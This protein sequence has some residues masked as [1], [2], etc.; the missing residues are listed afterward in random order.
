MDDGEARLTAGGGTAVRRQLRALAERRRLS[1]SQR[2]IA[3]FLIDHADEAGFLTS[4]DLAQRV[5]VSQPSATRFA[6][7]LGFAGYPEFRE[8]I[9]S[10]M[11]RP[12]ADLP[13]EEGSGELQRVITHE[14][15]N[16]TTL[17]EGLRDAD[18][19]TAV[20]RHL[21]SSRPLI[22]IGLR[23]S[24][25]L[26][27]LFVYFARM[28]H[29]DVR[30]VVEAGSAAEDLISQARD[31]GGSCVLVFGLPRYPRELLTLMEWSR[32]VGL[33]VHLITDQAIS[34]LNVAADATLTAPVG[35]DLVFDS[36]VAPVAL[37]MILLQKM[38]DALP[39]RQQQRLEEFD[40]NA[41]E[42]RVFLT[43]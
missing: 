18:V 37:S 6:A 4:V 19:V 27:S 11:L 2:R 34:P 43:P 7:A 23:V 24:A 33:R 15:R 41:V 29:P 1:P 30:L 25:P 13:A 10:W 22:V 28:V 12:D 14:I 17:A 8:T 9:R 40:A 16:L 35:V 3:R 42:R 20:G 5:G 21:A 26:A 39:S 36:Q 32:R 31:A 38:F